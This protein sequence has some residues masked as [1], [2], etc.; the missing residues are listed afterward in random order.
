M[1]RPIINTDVLIPKKPI[2]NIQV[3]AKTQYLPEQ[4]DPEAQQYA[5]AYSI[6][7]TNLGTIGARLLNRHWLI[8]DGNHA[9]QEVRGQG[10]IGEQP[11]L[12]AGESYHYTSGAVISTKVG[13]MQGSYQMI[14]DDGT[15][16]DAVISPFTLACPNMLH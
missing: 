3:V 11:H 16:F 9:V 14:A 12:K 5:F 8:I 7:L 15:Q 13:S 10:V 1:E 4:S 6:T 2:Y